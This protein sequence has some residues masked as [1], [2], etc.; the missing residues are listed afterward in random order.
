VH[1]ELST[2]HRVLKEEFTTPKV[3]NDNLELAYDLTINE[4]HV[5]T[6][7]VAKLDVATSC[8]D[9][10]VESIGKC[11][12]CKGKNVVVAESHDDTIKIKQDNEKIK[13]ENVKLKKD[14]EEQAKHNTIMVET[15]DHDKTLAYE[16]KKLKDE[17]QYLKLGLM[18][19][20]QEEDE[21]I[22]LEELDS[23]DDHIIKR[24]T[25]ENKKLKLEKEHL[26][27]GLAKFTRG[28]DLQSELFMNTIM[29]MDKSGIGYKA[30][31]S[32]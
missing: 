26:T 32:K 4:T 5:A 8:D 19:D 10:L 15:L 9:L 7:H 28:K 20:K 27:K 13:C 6:N 14:L 12:S 18:Y 1:V 22:I 11:G 3:N 17:N 24:L 16:N 25:L 30:Q 29:K 21:S 31:Q 23:K 2:R